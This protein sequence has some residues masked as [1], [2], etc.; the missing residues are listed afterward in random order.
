MQFSEISIKTKHKIFQHINNKKFWKH[1]LNQTELRSVWERHSVSIWAS[2][3]A[4]LKR[5]LEARVCDTCL[6]QRRRH[7]S[8]RAVHLVTGWK[9][10]SAHSRT[11]TCS[12]PTV[13]TSSHAASAEAREHLAKNFER[14][15][16]RSDDGG[17]AEAVRYQREVR[18]RSLDRLV[19][20]RLHVL[21]HTERRALRVQ[22]LHQRL[23]RLSAGP[24]YAEWPRDCSALFET[25][26]R[27]QIKQSMAH[28]VCSIFWR[29]WRRA[30]SSR[31]RWLAT[32][33]CGNSFSQI[34]L[35]SRA[36]RTASPTS[37]SKQ[38][39][40]VLVQYTLVR[41]S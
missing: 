14:G 13:P 17:R 38:N 7:M 25:S 30:S 26:C 4:D 39:I 2:A 32:C 12:A 22:Q 9:G 11:P 34:M 23:Q 29:V 40:L 10:T 16:E 24:N 18:E 35:K 31:I 3:S 21:H 33:A 27:F 28:F 37:A 36:I 5:K 6:R 20:Q 1:N 19:Q 41:Y 8:R 15:V